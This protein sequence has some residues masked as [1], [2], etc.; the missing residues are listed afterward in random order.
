MSVFISSLTPQLNTSTLYFFCTTD[1]LHLLCLIICSR[2]YG[3]GLFVVPLQSSFAK[4]NTPKDE[5][6]VNTWMYCG[7]NMSHGVCTYTCMHVP[8]CTGTHCH[9]RM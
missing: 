4:R 2:F 5:G 8:T 1:S 6:T 9:I 7:D 3:L